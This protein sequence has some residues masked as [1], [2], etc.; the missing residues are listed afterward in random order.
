MRCDRLRILQLCKR[1]LTG[2][3][4]QR[5]V[6]DAIAAIDERVEGEASDDARLGSFDDSLAV[7]EGIADNS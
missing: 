3:S 1:E 4:R 7:S 5:D 6:D 2:W